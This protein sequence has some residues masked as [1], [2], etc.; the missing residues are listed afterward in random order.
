MMDPLQAPSGCSSSEAEKHAHG[1]AVATK[2]VDTGAALIAGMSG[3]L[4]PDDA[5]RVRRKIDFGILPM[6]CTLYWIQF[7]DKATL[8]SSA[9]LGIQKDTHLSTDQYDHSMSCTRY[10]FSHRYR[11]GTI[12]WALCSTLAIYYSNIRRISRSSVSLWV[13]GLASIS[14]SGELRWPATQPAPTSLA[15][16]SRVL[17]WACVRGASQLAS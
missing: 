10:S 16:S 8:G 3:D 11:S 1:I 7:M 9:I 13:D 4:D 17:S 14:L 15:F 12:G 5:A 6:M 2:D